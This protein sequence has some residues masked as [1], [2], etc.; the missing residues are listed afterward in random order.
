[1]DNL[2][3]ASEIKAIL[4]V[5]DIRAVVD[6]E[7]LDEVFT[8]WGA[9]APRTPF[10]GVQ[11]LAP[12]TWALWRGG[13]VVTRRYFTLE[14]DEEASDERSALAV[15]DGLMRSA[16]DVRSLA[17]VPVGSYLSGGLDSSIISTLASGA[18]EETLRTFSVAFNDPS[19]DES[20]HQRS[21]AA[22]LGS[23]HAE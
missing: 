23:D 6:P 8:F 5:G 22:G 16:V 18:C 1:G 12:G 11:S 15:L 14:Y 2:Y 9:R 7:G 20:V 4:A 3:F 17:D 13:D 10:R 21:V 19:L